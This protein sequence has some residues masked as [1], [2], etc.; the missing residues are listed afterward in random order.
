[1][2][3]QLYMHEAFPDWHVRQTGSHAACSHC[4]LGVCLQEHE[5]LWA[6][7]ALD[8]E[9]QP[10]GKLGELVS[11]KKDPTH[12]LALDRLQPAS[13]KCKLRCCLWLLH[14]KGQPLYA[15]VLLHHE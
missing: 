2:Y 8:Q 11:L 14:L 5:Q 1:M 15:V 13:G 3:K 10:A 6:R 4:K 12:C 9:P 7:G